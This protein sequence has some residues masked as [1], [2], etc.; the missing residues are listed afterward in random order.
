V[1]SAKQQTNK[2]SKGWGRTACRTSHKGAKEKFKKIYRN[3]KNLHLNA[4]FVCFF[5]NVMLISF[6]TGTFNVT[7][8]SNSTHLNCRLGKIK[9][10]SKLATTRPWN[11]VLLVEFLLQACE[12]IPCE[13]CSVSSHRWIQGW[14]SVVAILHC[15]ARAI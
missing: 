7:R 13:G 10:C 14:L 12:L 4:F 11:I 6:V 1:L 5:S 9:L 2:H 3:G 8:A 15:W